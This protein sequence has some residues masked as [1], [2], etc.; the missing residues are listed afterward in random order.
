MVTNHFFRF[1]GKEKPCG[2]IDRH[3]WIY[4]EH[5]AFESKAFF[6]LDSKHS[7]RH[8]GQDSCKEIE[9]LNRILCLFEKRERPESQT[10][11]LIV[12]IF[13]Q[14]LQSRDLWECLTPK[15]KNKK[16]REKEKSFF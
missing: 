11:Y 9:R 3:H 4:N 16:A 5:K 6:S 1:F 2:K 13:L 15:M 12:H 8:P 7:S 14:A 10:S